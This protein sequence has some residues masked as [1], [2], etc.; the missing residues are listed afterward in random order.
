MSYETKITGEIMIHPPLAWKHVR[1]SVFLP[2]NVIS[3]STNE[4]IGKNVTLRLEEIIEDTDEGRLIR[5]HAVAVEATYGGYSGYEGKLVEHLQELV[6]A[7]PEHEFRG[8]I[9]GFGEDR[10]AP[11]L[12]RVKV[13]NRKVTKFTPS[14]IW[15]YES[16]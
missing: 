1:E 16:E 15:N 14:I 3:G 7:F 4:G 9:D 11:D 5:V 8:R 10:D 13:V 12:W 6:D 2:E